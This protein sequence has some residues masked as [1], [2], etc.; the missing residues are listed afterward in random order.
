MNFI[1]KSDIKLKKRKPDSHKGE[2]GVVLIIGGSEQFV[3]AVALAGLA[4]LR[5]GAD[6]AIVAAPEHTAWAVSCLS[7]DLITIKLPGK[8]L[9]T[10]HLKKTLALAKKADVVLIGNGLGL[11]PRTKSFVKKFAKRMTKLKKK[12][13]IDADGI[14]AVSLMDIDNAILTPHESEFEILLKNSRINKNNMQKNLK[15]NTILL[16]GKIDK[17]MSRKKTKFNKTGNAGLTRGGTGD[18]LAG[19]TAGFLA[20]GHSAF[21]SA[22]YAAY[23]NGLIGDILLKKK[24]GFTYLATDMVEEIKRVLSLKKRS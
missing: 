9:S 14:K 7:A 22:C 12:L 5:S 19:L 10:K 13:V 16:K 18:V 1:K 15:N 4:V 23:F 11:N 20:Q 6:L 3:G 24:K 17:I 21:D 2:N 8:Y